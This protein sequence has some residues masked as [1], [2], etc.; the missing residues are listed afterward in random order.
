ML[1][2]ILNPSIL[3]ASPSPKGLKGI[4]EHGGMGESP[5]PGKNQ[6]SGLNGNGQGLRSRKIDKNGYDIDGLM[7]LGIDPLRHQSEG[8]S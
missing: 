6:A 2:A 4:E 5:E 1:L 8:L 7:G 3:Q